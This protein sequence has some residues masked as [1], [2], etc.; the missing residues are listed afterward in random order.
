MILDDSSSALDYATD[1]ALRRAL[2]DECGGMTV[3][4]V[5]QRVSAVESADLILVLDDGVLP[6]R[7]LT[8]NYFAPARLIRRSTGY[9]IPHAEGKEAGV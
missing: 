4:V 2:R 7:E 9:R 1:A 6:A 8:K 3:L 5:S